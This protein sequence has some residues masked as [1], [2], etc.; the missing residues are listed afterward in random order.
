MIDAGG[1]VR[2]FAVPGAME[3]SRKD[4][5]G[6][7][8]FARTWGGKGVAWLQV[9]GPGEPVDVLH[10]VEVDLPFLLRAIKGTVES[11]ITEKMNELLG[12]A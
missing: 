3:F 5:E 11:R 2:G 1:V 10:R 9:T 4:F 12:K 7:V 8:E 6:L